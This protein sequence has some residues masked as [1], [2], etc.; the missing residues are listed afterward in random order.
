MDGNR[1][2]DVRGWRLAKQRNDDDPVNEWVKG[3]TGI[4]AQPSATNVNGLHAT[5]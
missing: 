1:L 4:E 3:K 5:L 2:V